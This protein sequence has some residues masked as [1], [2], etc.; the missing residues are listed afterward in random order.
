MPPQAGASATAAAAEARRLDMPGPLA[1]ADLLL[2]E[3]AAAERAASPLS[4]RETEVAD[5]VLQAL[6][7]R[8]IADRLV[9]SERTV[10]SHV[11]AILRKAGVTSRTEYLARHAGTPVQEEPR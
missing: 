2:A 9:L 7:N 1:R 5:L 11:S 6:S 4:A 10:E 3:L 8:Q